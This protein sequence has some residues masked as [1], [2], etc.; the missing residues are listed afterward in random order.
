[1]AQIATPLPDQTTRVTR[2]SHDLPLF[3]RIVTVSPVATL[4]LRTRAPQAP[5]LSF[6]GDASIFLVSPA[7]ERR[8]EHATPKRAQGAGSVVSRTLPG[9]RTL[10]GLARR[11]EEETPA[12]GRP[13]A[14]SSL[15]RWTWG[16]ARV[17]LCTRRA[18]SRGTRGTVAAHGARPSGRA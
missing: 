5:D 6:V 9:A 13:S 2:A 18:A 16:P 10:G 15:D 14:C 17:G 3:V 12:R 11:N 1:M 8:G 7:L 4:S